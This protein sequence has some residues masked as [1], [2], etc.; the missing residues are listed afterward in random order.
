MQ[1]SPQTWRE[2][3]GQL[4]E[5]PAERQRV[6]E[7]LGVTPY[8]ITRWVEGIS[9]PRV[10]NLK[11]LPE[12]FPAY[13]QLFSDLIQAELVPNAPPLSTLSVTSPTLEIP[14]EYLA[15]VLTAYAT[16][17]GPFRAWSIRTLTLQ[18]AIRQLDPDL[19]GMEITVAQCIPPVLG[20]PIRSLCE[21]MGVGTGSWDSRVGWR[22]FF[23]GA[24]SLAG[25]TVGR[26]EPGVVQN[27]D[28]GEGL[29]PFRRTPYEKSAA[30]WPLQRAGK[31][32]GCLLVSSAQINYFTPLRLSSI[33]IYANTLALS[34]R[35]EEFYDLRQIALHEMPLLSQQEASTIFAQLRERI[36]SLRRERA[37]QISEAEA[38]CLA[39]Q[40]IEAELLAAKHSRR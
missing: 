12:V 34:F 21:R 15:R 16:T 2:L 8:T 17:S 20:E 35:D 22:L 18:Q 19:L 31:L 38:E 1:Y 3:L 13:S 24:E 14:S 32:A 40:Q 7:E 26:G 4:T 27:M 9:E 29:L 10:Q 5:R 39:L 36:A 30:A 33:E 25:W 23:L 11:R 28:Q 6:A 37:F